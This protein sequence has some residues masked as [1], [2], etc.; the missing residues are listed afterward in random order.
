MGKERNTIRQ[1]CYQR[2]KYPTQLPAKKHDI[3]SKNITTQHH[4]EEPVLV[5]VVYDYMGE[6]H[7]DIRSMGEVLRMACALRSM[8]YAVYHEQRPSEPSHPVCKDLRSV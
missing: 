3:T 5:T 1:T 7:E 8:Q 4:D 6:V 2:L